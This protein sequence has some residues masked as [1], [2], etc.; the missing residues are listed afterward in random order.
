MILKTC[1]L[2][3]LISRVKHGVSSD[4]ETAGVREAAADPCKSLDGNPRWLKFLESLQSKGFFQ[5]EVEGSKLYQQLLSSAKE[6]FVSHLL[7][8]SDTPTL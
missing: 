8:E 4:S 1:G 5:N 7:D 2:E 3:I 6:Y